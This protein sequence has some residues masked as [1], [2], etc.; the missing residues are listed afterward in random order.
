[1]TPDDR[2]AIDGLFQRIAAVEQ[3]A[4]EP[5]DPDAEALIARR[6]SDQPSAA[7]YMAQT[8]VVQQQ[9]LEQAE[10]R[11]A[12]L[13]E[14]V[15][16]RQGWGQQSRQQPYADERNNPGP[17]SRGAPGFSGGGFLAGA[18]QT[19]MGVAGGVLLGNMIGGLF[20]AGEAHAAEPNAG[21]DHGDAGGAADP[22]GDTD[23]G[24]DAGEFDGG[25]D[26]DLGGDF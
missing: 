24:F 2:R 19:A 10:R 1:M 15:E 22:G 7:Y 4:V 16:R 11:I 23:P 6:L 5:R 20:G 21:A 3:R 8:V 14:Q 17:W 9:A 26:F 13:E 12:E 25:G 18:M